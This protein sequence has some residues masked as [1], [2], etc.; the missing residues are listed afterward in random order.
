MMRGSGCILTFDPPSIA[1]PR[2]G[3]L[4]LTWTRTRPPGSIVDRWC[5]VVVACVDTHE[6]VSQNSRH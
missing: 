3:L 6:P 2:K 1:M 5:C 4:F